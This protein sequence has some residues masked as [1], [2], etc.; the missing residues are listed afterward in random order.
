MNATQASPLEVNATQASPLEVNATQASPL[1]VNATPAQA[2][3]LKTIA[4]MYKSTRGC[5]PS[6]IE[7]EN[8]LY[9]S[10]I[11]PYGQG[12]TKEALELAKKKGIEK[13]ITMLMASRVVERTAESIVKFIFLYMQQFDPKD[14]GDYLGSD[15]GTTREGQEL[16]DQIRYRFLRTCHYTG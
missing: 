8:N 14:L 3:P 11:S 6:H 9:G 10:A 5:V 16:M 13:C 2:S 4:E 7:L 1:E 12:V 15:G